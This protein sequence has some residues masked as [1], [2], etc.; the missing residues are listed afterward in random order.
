MVVTF[1]MKF[2]TAAALKSNIELKYK[3]HKHLK[4]GPVMS[5]C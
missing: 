1:S 2:L 4:V 5:Y 3:S